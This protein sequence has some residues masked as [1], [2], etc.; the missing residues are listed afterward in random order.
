MNEPVFLFTTCQTRAERTLKAEIARHWPDFRPAF[1]R[2]GF[3]TFKLPENHGLAGNF[4]L[5]SVFAR[6]HGFSIGKFTGETEAALAQSLRESIREQHFDAL[7]VW[8]RNERASEFFPTAVAAISDALDLPSVRLAE[9]AISACLSRIAPAEHQR[10][11]DCALVEPRE[12]WLGYHNTTT[13]ET[14]WPG[15]IYPATLPE[16]AVSRAYLKMDEALA[17]SQLPVKPGEHVAEVGCSP[18]GASQALLDRKLIVMGIDPAI[19][20]ERVTAHP[21]FTHVRKRGHEVKRREFRKTRWL[22]AD[23]NVAP[24]YTLDTV[25]SIVK[26]SEVHIRGMLLTLKL[27]EWS[28]ASQ[29]PAYLEQIRGWGYGNVRARQLSHN[30]QEICVAATTSS[31]PR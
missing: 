16:H 29:I 12:W 19:V 11:L 20:D 22:M 31:P 14:R 7:H 9:G 5:T 28:L 4:D 24:Q 10:I 1:S 15:G 30:R 8:A 23:M 6:A 3:V 21:D 2:P 13:P 26:H 18:G 25:E 27:L 17:W